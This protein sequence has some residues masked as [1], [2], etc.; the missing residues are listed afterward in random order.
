MQEGERITLLDVLLRL[1]WKRNGRPSAL[2]LFPLASRQPFGSSPPCCEVAYP[3]ESGS[4]TYSGLVMPDWWRDF[5]GRPAPS[6]DF[7]RPCGGCLA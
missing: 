2:I 7:V 1:F 6:W 3:V 5:D 4:S